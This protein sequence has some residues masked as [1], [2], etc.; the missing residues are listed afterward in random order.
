MKNKQFLK[1]PLIIGIAVVMNLF[2]A[3]AIKVS[4][5]S[6][7]Y[8]DFCP[9]QQKIDRIMGAEECLRIGGQW[10]ASYA[11]KDNPGYC[12][13]EFRCQNNWE[14]FRKVYEKNVFMIL[15]ALGVI[16]VALS[17]LSGINQVLATAFSFGGVFTFI[18]ASFRYWDLAPDWL[19]L[20]ILGVALVA[21]IWLGVKKFSDMK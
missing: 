1:W 20:S 14:I 8:Q 16:S 11:D 6:K 21:L 7:D 17:F 18:V 13:R 2:F 10:D 19:H 12:N 9:R 5:P 4:Y 3:Y 15:V